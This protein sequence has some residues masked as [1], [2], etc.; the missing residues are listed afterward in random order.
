[1]RRISAHYIYLGDGS[2]LKYGILTVSDDGTVLSIEDTKGVMKESAKVEFYPG[3]LIPGMVNAHCH[4]ELTHAKGC[5]PRNL[6]LSGFLK[7][8]ISLP[9]VDSDK[10]SAMMGAA[11]RMMY[12]SGISVVGDISNGDSSFDTKQKSKI[13]YHTFV[14]ALGLDSSKA[15]GSFSYVRTVYDEA[16]NR[17]LSASIVPHA[18]YSVSRELMSMINQFDANSIVT[19]HNQESDSENDLF[20]RGEGKMATHLTHNIGFDMSEFPVLRHS[21]IHYHGSMI[22]KSHTLLLVHNTFMSREDL[23]F[24]LNLREGAKT[25]FVLCPKSNIYIEGSLPNIEMFRDEVVSLAIGTDSLSSNDTLS[26]M[27]EIKVIQ[28]NF[29][30]I[31]LNELVQMATSNGAKALLLEEQYG[32]IAVGKKPGIVL[33]KDVDLKNHRLRATSNSIR[34]I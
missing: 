4:L 14:E 20:I 28:N 34:I 10:R 23:D 33:L 31:S 3:I 32:T 8:V 27:E 12:E 9:D 1:M 11:D 17:G 19:I 16:L 26:M 30:D 25:T 5:I 21:S 22:D 7:N 6:E 15:E 2:I 13:Y 29:P 24:I 18:P